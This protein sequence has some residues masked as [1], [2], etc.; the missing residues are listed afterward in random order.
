[1]ENEVVTIIIESLKVAAP[2]CAVLMSF[3]IWREQKRNQ[4]EQALV[5]AETQKEIAN[6]NAKNSIELKQRE[7]ELKF[8]EEI[9]KLRLVEY[10]KAKKLISGLINDFHEPSIERLKDTIDVLAS[11]PDCVFSFDKKIADVWAESQREM[12]SVLQLATNSENPNK[13]ISRF[14]TKIRYHLVA[15]L[16]EINH[17]LL[18]LNDL[19][20][21]RENNLTQIA[22]LKHQQLSFESLLKP[23]DTT[24]E[25]PKEQTP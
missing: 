23:S 25:H 11:D 14:A 8:F 19:D 12:F 7:F 4:I 21:L 2:L 24:S 16:L 20:E 3:L 22:N 15:I 10:N 13:T 5:N 6:L 18:S 17:G 1:M 9:I